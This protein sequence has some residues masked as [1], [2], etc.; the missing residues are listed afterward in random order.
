MFRIRIKLGILIWIRIRNP[1][2]DPCRPW[3]QKTREKKSCFEL[4]VLSRGLEVCTV[5][6]KSTALVKKGTLFVLLEAMSPVRHVDGFRTLLG[7]IVIGRP[8]TVNISLCLWGRP[9]VFKNRL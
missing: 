9:P 3:P 4:D 2:Q 6:W 1:V 8:R 7:T 5:A